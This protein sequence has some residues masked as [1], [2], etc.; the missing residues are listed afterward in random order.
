ME[1]LDIPEAFQTKLRLLIVSALVNGAKSF[2]D[3]QA[4][5]SSTAG[6]LSVQLSKLEEWGYVTITKGF[7]GK[8]PHTSVAL[9]EMGLR[10]FKE[11]VQLLNR[12]IQK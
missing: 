1:M 9:T 6:N 12:L 2:G 5:T 8:R 10:S 7:V 3:L 4:I 11:Y